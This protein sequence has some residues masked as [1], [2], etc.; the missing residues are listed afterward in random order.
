MSIEKQCSKDSLW[1]CE[2]TNT[3]KKKK[4]KQY[5]FIKGERGLLLTKWLD[6][7]AFMWRERFS[8]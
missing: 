4:N 3:K 6:L 8:Q 5:A 1:E 7:G 2:A